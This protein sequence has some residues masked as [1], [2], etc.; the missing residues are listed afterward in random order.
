MTKRVSRF[1]VLFAMCF[2]LQACGWTS[3]TPQTVKVLA[4]H[5]TVSGDTLG[6]WSSRWWQWA[7]AAAPEQS[8]IRDL[9]G[10]DCAV[11]QSGPVWFLAG[12]YDSEP[13]VRSCE[14]PAG[15]YVFFPIINFIESAESAGAVCAELS[16]IVESR[17]DT[18]THVQVAIDG[19]PVPEPDAHREKSPSCFDPYRLVGGESSG[20]YLSSG[21][22]FWIMLE[23]LPIGRH[24]LEFDADSDWFSQDITY[25]L[26]VK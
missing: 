17:F 20:A 23:P 9:T 19:T 15:K 14:V 3:A 5:A 10:A 7:L 6:T 13:V 16:A 4:P 24:V 11:G 8:P 26:E 2:L 25:N 21:D 12:S 1:F 18:V 22:G